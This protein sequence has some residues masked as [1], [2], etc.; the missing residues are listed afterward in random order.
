MNLTYFQPRKRRNEENNNYAL[1]I[2]FVTKTSDIRYF[3]QKIRSDVKTSETATLVTIYK[4]SFL[5]SACQQRWSDSDF[6][7]SDP[8]LFLKNDIRIRSESFF[9]WSHTIS[10][11]KLS[12]SVLWCTTYIFV[13]CLFCVTRQNNFWSYFAFSWIGLVE[14]VTWQVW[15]TCPA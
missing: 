6:L 8:I 5:K 9:A 12:E 2:R 10:V 11:R 3:S 7:L 15:N 4:K 14:V 13:L 1:N